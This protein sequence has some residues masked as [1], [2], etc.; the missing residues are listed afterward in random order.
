MYFQLVKT[1]KIS[2]EHE[3]Y[4][5]LK[6]TSGISIVGTSASACCSTCIAQ[7]SDILPTN[8]DVT[9]TRGKANRYR[10]ERSRTETNKTR[11]SFELINEF[12]A[13][14][15]IYSN[16]GDGEASKQMKS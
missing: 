3:S 4:S 5:R 8:S 12:Y 15:D 6:H 7:S 2:Q 9:P 14:D 16:K 13:W 1:S 10:N 11:N